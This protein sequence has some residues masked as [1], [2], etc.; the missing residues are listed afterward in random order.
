MSI[1]HIFLDRFCIPL[2][3]KKMAVSKN[4]KYA[5]YTRGKQNLDPI[6]EQLFNND[7]VVA[8]ID[9]SS[10]LEHLKTNADRCAISTFDNNFATIICS[11]LDSIQ[12]RFL[13]KTK[14]PKISH[15]Y[16]D[17]GTL[18]K[19]GARNFSLCTFAGDLNLQ[20][21]YMLED[22]VGRHKGQ[23]CFVAGNGPSLNQIDMTKLNNEIVFG[24]NRCYLGYPDWGFDFPYWGIMDRLQVEEYA[25]EYE[26]N[27]PSSS[28]V[29]YPFEYLPFIQFKKSCPVNFSYDSRPPIRFSNSPEILHLGYTVTYMLLQIAVIMGCN[30][31]YLI[32]TDHKYNLATAPASPTTIQKS[33]SYL[34]HRLKQ[35]FGKISNFISGGGRERADK[36]SQPVLPALWKA[37]DATQPTHFNEAYTA[38]QKKFVMPKPEKLDEAFQVAADWAKDNSV[39]ILNATPGSALMAFD[40][41]DYKDL[42]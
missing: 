36:D 37:A 15:L 12:L 6:Y 8:V 39:D 4:R 23:R 24:S 14:I 11:T 2:T 22:F 16:Q 40:R 20:M 33:T 18:W 10:G 35:G 31:I 1:Q 41:V 29:F 28:V 19:L 32:G 9:F 42:F 21:D 17:I 27:I 30:P 26:N 38:G 3:Q 7:L 34:Q 13:E 25:T 5:L